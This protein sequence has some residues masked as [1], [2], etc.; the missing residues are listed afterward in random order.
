MRFIDKITGAKLDTDNEF[1]IEQLKK[2]P[3]RYEEA[4][5]EVKKATEDKK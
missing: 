4:K 2:Y 3:E 1:V 5:K